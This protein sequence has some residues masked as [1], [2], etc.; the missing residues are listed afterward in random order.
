MYACLLCGVY[1]TDLVSQRT[2]SS[3]AVP[4]HVAQH[5]YMSD[6]AT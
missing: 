6:K 4:Y 5:D 1:M 2:A 3:H